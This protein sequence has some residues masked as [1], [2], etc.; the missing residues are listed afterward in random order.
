M[1]SSPDSEIKKPKANENTGYK[2]SQ[3]TQLDAEA[4]A[5]DPLVV[6]RLS[7]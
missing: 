3:K 7:E 2:K 6:N 5:N 4:V 1:Q